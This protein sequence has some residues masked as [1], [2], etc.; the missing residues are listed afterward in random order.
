VPRSG[1]S[2]T[3]LSLM[4]FSH[5]FR[6]TAILRETGLSQQWRASEDSLNPPEELPRRIVQ[7]S[8]QS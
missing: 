2:G 8:L 4:T 6:M 1:S 5:W 7:N 3:H